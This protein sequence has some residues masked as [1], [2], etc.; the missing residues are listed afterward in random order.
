[1][2]AYVTQEQVGVAVGAVADVHLAM[3]SFPGTRNKGQ[4][5]EDILRLV[6]VMKCDST[7]F[8]KST[9]TQ[10]RITSQNEEQDFD[11]FAFANRLQR[12]D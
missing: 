2:C 12:E 1:M 7:Q 4:E 10:R 3:R 11:L 6:M 8:H 9:Q 5:N